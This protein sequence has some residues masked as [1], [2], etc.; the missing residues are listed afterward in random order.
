[1]P[2][3]SVDAQIEKIIED[4]NVFPEHVMTAAI[5]ALNRT[6]DWLKNN[7]AKEVSAEQRIKL[8][9]IRDRIV[10]RRAS[11]NNLETKLSCKLTKV[12]VKDFDDVKQTPVGV[13]A[14]GV[15]YSH[16]F[17]ADLRG[18][19]RKGVYRR[20]G[21]DRFPV[22]SVTVELL[23]NDVINRIEDLVGTEAKGIFEKRF[24]HNLT[25]LT[26]RL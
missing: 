24:L 1:M 10:M 23:S 17:I 7:I 2:Q 3:V 12:Y 26:G 4:L 9:M 14:G 16:A 19:G 25:K 18:F 21:K 6:G 22:K 13:R 20:V 8:K 5:D 15:M 11:K